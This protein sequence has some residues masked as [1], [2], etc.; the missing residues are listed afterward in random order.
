MHISL[1]WLKDF[2]DIKMDP[3]DLG[4]ELTLKTAEVETVEDQSHAFDNMVAG[5]VT[6]L[7][8]HPD[9]DRLQIAKVSVGKETL[10]IVCGGANLKE[11]MY[12]AVTKIGA[13]VK[14]H[15]EG[16]LVTLEKAKVRGVESYGMI[17]A[18][19]EMGLED[20]S[21]GPHDIMNL[22][23]IKPKPGT[24]LSKI[25]KKDDV[26]LEFDNKSLTHRPDLWGHYGIARE[27]AAITGA[28]LKPYNPNPKIPSKGESPKVKVEDQEL[29]PRYCG[30]IIN[31]IKVEDSPEWL[32]ARLKAV[33]HGSHGNI[34]DVTNYISA[35]LGQPM[36]AFDKSFIN[37]GVVVR[38]AKKGEKITTLD[39]KKRT[40]NE[41]MLVIADHKKPVAI[42]GVMGGENSEINSNTT[43]I[44]LEAATFNASSVRK[45][46]TKLG[47]RTDSVQRFEKSLDPN[48]PELAIKRA[49]ELILSLCPGALIGGPITDIQKFSK[50]PLKL[51]LNITKTQS[52]IGVE[53]PAKQIKSI[54]E[55]LEFKVGKKN[56]TTFTVEV[57]TFRATKDV[58]AEDDL[59]EEVARLY[60]YENIAP[61]LPKLPIRLP[62]ENT[63]RFAKHRARD[64]FSHGLGFDEVYNYSFYGLKEIK[65]CMMS[66]D[67]H[68]KL[69]NYLSEDQTHIR[70]SMTPNLLKN[71]QLN[72]KN[73]DDIKIYE[74]GRTYTD[75]GEFYPQEIKKIGGA[76]MHKSTE[77]DPFYEAKGAVEAFLAHFNIDASPAKGIKNVPYAHPQKALS[78][79][80]HSGQT[81]AVVFAIHPAVQKNHD[82]QNYKIANFSINFTEAL[83]LNPPTTKFTEI[84]KFPSSTFDVSVL[85]KKDTEIQTLKDAIKKAN[86]DLISQI[87]LFDIYE[88]PNLKANHK[89]VAFKI[90]LQDISQ[91]LT[92]QSLKDT[93]ARVFKNLKS[94]GGEIRGGQ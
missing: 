54:L 73:F 37:G 80:D 47:L 94:I 28:K 74:I 21:A 72:A 40:L 14:W 84:P 67:Q 17:A 19:E 45:T 1:N 7:K 76:I 22:S 27:I 57:P 34:V 53:I 25:F 33:G 4:N 24:P 79:I 85:I 32:K 6:G 30:L 89:A 82:L 44:I 88:G 38:R 68:L 36:H 93:Q 63:E 11:D 43:S 8:K 3:K 62:K 2:V 9:A 50:T 86:P 13:R 58:T 69:Q 18:A 46:S 20:P 77:K 23:S 26:I 55:S 65:D 60:G 90:T 15:G 31:N 56:A 91:T 59:I 52:K 51:D 10:Q 5:L 64:L 39:D 81:V 70:K 75:I 92:D 71:L 66:E 87:T 12:V 29:C 35:E 48:L 78:Y 49:A 83:R 42:A 41:N 16:E 61:D